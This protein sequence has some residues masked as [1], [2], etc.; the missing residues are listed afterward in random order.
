M[1]FP[2]PASTH[3]LYPFVFSFRSLVNEVELGLQTDAITQQTF[4][5]I[6]GGRATGG[7]GGI[8]RACLIQ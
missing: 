7:D 5:S 1:W 4:R 3:F 2:N 6:S 8:I